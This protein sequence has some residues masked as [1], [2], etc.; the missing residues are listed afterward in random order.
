MDECMHKTGDADKSAQIPADTLVASLFCFELGWVQPIDRR[1]A[2]CPFHHH[3]CIEVVYH[4]RGSG[5]TAL[6]SGTKVSFEEGS[7]VI[8][9]PGMVHNQI[10][11][12]PEAVD[13]VVQLSP[14]SPRA[15]LPP[16]ECLYVPPL[17]DDG[18]MSLLE[19]LAGQAVPMGAD[20]RIAASLDASRLMHGLL[21]LG[22]RTQQAAATRTP[23]EQAAYEARDLIRNQYRAVRHLRDT[24]ARLGIGYDTLR[25]T[26]KRV[27]GMTMKQWLAQ[28]R[29][30]QACALLRNT[31]LT[32]VVIAELSGFTD[33]QHFC[34][35]FRKRTGRTPGEYRRQSSTRR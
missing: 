33:A 31:A 10:A 17:S 24:A 6:E 25:R 5:T 7:V 29:I 32:Q 8:Y 16:R 35:D 26:F 27:H 1:L 22:S 23:A 14:A 19:S 15:A 2:H 12:T 4:R 13:V 28:V 34:A 3:S 11:R 30:E 20:E 21:H 18:L 9:P